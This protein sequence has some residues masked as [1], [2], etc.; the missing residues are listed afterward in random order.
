[1][2]AAAALSRSTFLLTAAALLL[3]TAALAGPAFLLTSAAR[4]LQ[5]LLLLVKIVLRHG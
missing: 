1:L 2:L 5:L 3:C 4:G